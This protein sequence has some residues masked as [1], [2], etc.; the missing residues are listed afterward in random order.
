MTDLRHWIATAIAEVD[1]WRGVTDPAILADAVIAALALTQ[2]DNLH[3]IVQ[4]RYI[5]GWIPKK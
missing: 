3:N 2:Y 5:T 4:H 1:D